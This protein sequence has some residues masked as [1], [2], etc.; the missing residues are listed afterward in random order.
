[1]TN[2]IIKS[3]KIGEGMY[4]HE[5]FNNEGKL[6]GDGDVLENGK[7]VQE[8]LYYYSI[9][10]VPFMRNNKIDISK[11]EFELTKNGK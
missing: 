7:T 2:Y 8:A 5:L 1:M 9:S 6:M 4:N 11:L 10:A 3:N